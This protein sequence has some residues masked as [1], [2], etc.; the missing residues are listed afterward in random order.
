[1]LKS[2]EESM[3]S[4]PLTQPS[5]ARDSVAAFDSVFK[6]S[7]GDAMAEGQWHQLLAGMGAEMSG[8]LRQ[9]MAGL[10]ELART[11]RLGKQEAKWLIEPLQRLYRVGISAQKLSHM[12]TQ[13]F[14]RA[15]ETVSLDE[16]LADAIAHHQL[17]CGQHKIAA[18]LAHVDVVAEP[19]ALASAMD[20]LLSWSLNLG[21]DIHIKLVRERGRPRSEV[22]VRIKALNKHADDDRHLNS[23]DWYML[24]Q[25][26]RIK[27]VRVK[28]KVET[29]RDRVRVIVQFDRVMNQHSGL[30]VLEMEADD[31]TGGPMFD[32]NRTEV[33]CVM[34]RNDLAVLVHHTLR[35]QVRH[36]RTLDDL[37]VLA[38]ASQGPDC[39]V[40]VPE[41]L[42]TDA[43]R[44]WRRSLQE[45]RGRGLAVVEISAEANVFDVGGFGPHSVSRVSANNLPEK[46][47]AAIVFELSHVATASR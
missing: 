42:Q 2:F 11:N 26:A 39:V 31:L 1:M 15:G 29:E 44:H 22:W 25:L 7:L 18:D 46:L 27:G 17:R 16:V 13:T 10:A 45:V 43:F 33:W 30:A 24:W 12:A 5:F 38:D 47:L 4:A 35:P 19:E 9:T 6:Q 23:V 40:S 14:S 3:A 28:R 20:C 37:R 21:Q 36:L 34:P 41:Y 32:P 8:S